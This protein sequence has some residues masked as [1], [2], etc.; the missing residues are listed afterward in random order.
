MQRLLE[1]LA[2]HP[3][4]SGAAVAIAVAVI[5]NEVRE[6][7]QSF[8]ALSAAAAV[9]LM[10]QGALLLDIRAKDAYEA[11][12]IGEARNLPEAELASAADTLKKWRE[13][14]VIV[15]CDSGMRSATAARTLSKLG[16]P[17]VFS[18]AGGIEGWRKD[19]LPVVKGAPGKAQ[20]K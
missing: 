17:K 3:Y 4:L 19:N 20:G 1:Y 7:M 8:A 15:Y 5:A 6:R 13:K 11:G 10:N 12:H 9:P 2:H 14:N 16:F 18:L